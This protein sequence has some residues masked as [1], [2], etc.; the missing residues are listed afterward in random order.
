[1]LSKET[2]IIKFAILQINLDLIQLWVSA[3]SAINQCCFKYYELCSIRCRHLIMNCS[4][5]LTSCEWV[6][7]TLWVLKLFLQGARLS[8][9]LVSSISIRALITGIRV[10]DASLRRASRSAMPGSWCLGWGR[11]C[12]HLRKIKGNILIYLVTKQQFKK[13]KKQK[14][15]SKQDRLDMCPQSIQLQ[16][17]DYCEN[18]IGLFEGMVIFCHHLAGQ[19]E[20]KVT[21]HWWHSVLPYIYWVTAAGQDGVK[22]CRHVKRNFF[23]CE[24]LK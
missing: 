20:D 14:P 11:D 2:V 19:L 8:V 12:S 24:S 21:S 13:K 16:M 10:Q 6:W 18:L 5:F 3:K 15:T 23:F 9:A 1:M 22:D 4:W 17:T 7:V